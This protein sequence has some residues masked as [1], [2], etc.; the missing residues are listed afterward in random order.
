M[1]SSTA[2][3]L[4]LIGVLTPRLADAQPYGVQSTAVRDNALHR[5]SVQFAA[6]ATLQGGDVQS[7][8]FGYSPNRQ[9]TVL[10][11]ADRSHVSTRVEQF[12]RG[13]AMTRGGTSTLVSGELRFEPDPDRR[14]SPY[15]LVGI[16]RGVSRPN[17]NRFFPDRVS[18]STGM[19]FSGVGFRVPVARNFDLVAEARVALATERDVLMLSVPIRGG[20]AWRF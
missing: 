19:L 8:S 11:N 16:G 14:V 10:I 7:V 5:F 6:G 17:V 15:L 9:L 1:R 20:I 3:A 18:N 4:F 12:E 2:A 13:G